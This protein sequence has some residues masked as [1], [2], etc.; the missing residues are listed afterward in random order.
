MAHKLNPKRPAFFAVL[1]ALLLSSCSMDPA[2]YSTGLSSSSSQPTSST[3]QTSESTSQSSKESSSQSQPSTSSSSESSSS[4]PIASYTITWKCGDEVLEVDNNVK[5]GELPVYNGA[6][7]T[8]ESTDRYDYVF[9]TWDPEVAPASRDQVYIAAFTRVEKTFTIT[10]KND[11]GSVLLTQDNVAYGTLPNYEGT[12]SKA[13]SESVDYSFKGWDPEIKRATKDVVY[14]ATYTESTRKYDITWLNED[15]TELATTKVEYGKLPA[16]C[17][18]TPTKESD[19]QYDYV[20]EG[21]DPAITKVSENTSYKAKF[22][23][24]PKTFTITWINDDD[25]VIDTTQVKLGEMPTH[26][27]PTANAQAEEGQA[28]LFKGWEPALTKATGEATY[29]AKYEEVTAT[30]KITW[31]NDDDSVIDT[32][33]VEYNVVPTHDDPSKEATGQYTYSFKGWDKEIVPAK[34]DATYKAVYDSTVNKYTVTF[35]NDDGT[36]LETKEVEYG[37]TPAYTGETP[38]KESTVQYS[39]A[40]KGWDP[41]LTGVT[42]NVTY[43]A[44]YTQTTRKYT[45]TWKDYDD[46][47]IATTQ[48]EY[49]KTPSRTGPTRADD[50][51]YHYSFKAWDPTIK[52]VDGDATYKATYSQSVITNDYLPDVVYFTNNKNWSNVYAYAWNDKGANKDWPGAS[53]T[54]FK[55]NENDEYVYKVEGMS[56]YTKIIF[57]NNNGSQTVDISAKDLPIKEGVRD[58]A[59]YLTTQSNS[60]WKVGTWYESGV[61]VA[62][63]THFKNKGQNIL[64]C[65]DWSLATIKANLDDIAA[66]GFNAIQTSPVQPVKDY[67]QS[68]NDT[69]RTWWRFYQP[70][71]LCIGNST[72]NILFSS[73]DGASELAD[74]AQ[75]A[76]K[77]GIRIIV[78]VIVNHLADGNGN[79]GL[80]SQIANFNSEIYNDTAHTLHNPNGKVAVDYNN[81]YSITHADAFGKDLNTSNTTVQ[82]SVY[83]FLKQLIDCG[84]TGLRFDA[85]K[86]IETK[87]DSSGGSSFWENTLG[88]V[89]TYA[90]DTYGRTIW[91]YGEIINPTDGGR[92]YSQY[93]NDAWFYAVTGQ[94]GWHGLA[95]QNCVAWGESHDDYCGDN[96]SSH[97]SNT[98]QDVINANYANLAKNADTNMLYFVRPLKDE[99]VGVSIGDH[100]EW[101]WQNGDV[102]TA[103]AR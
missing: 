12:P 75:E 81:A 29:K 91:S 6:T 1:A 58:N 18:D 46:S 57:T 65:F 41:A 2:S 95:G 49:G 68:Y 15:D 50:A 19:S 77:R 37:T 30:Y 96:Y 3:S 47:V 44:T 4:T 45:I 67:D 43:K 27:T 32:T 20:F 34:E 80:H 93:L 52:A 22:K 16:Y 36:E 31:L 9:S 87:N 73:N 53:M 40:F 79:G 71:G 61:P 21:W 54:F 64:H 97:T 89:C 8:K 94:P 78:D 82:N 62:D 70:V 90:S 11:D 35:V 55:I 14:T 66:Q 7:P 60:K 56:S 99:K 24:V 13:S 5:A 28:W 39:Y 103:N 33:L 102:K 74:L 85:A 92:S 48:V 26:D 72:S 84:V 42:K 23:A 83:T 10:W 17:G 76:A 51:N 63:F 100:P 101:G 98:G 38:T 86:H 59:Y 69:N 88:K 25:E